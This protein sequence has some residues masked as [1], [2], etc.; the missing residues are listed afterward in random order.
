MAH[1]NPLAAVAQLQDVV[2]SLAPVLRPQVLPKGAS[3]SL[4]LMLAL[5]ATDAQKQQLRA[6]IQDTKPAAGNDDDAELEAQVVGAF[7]VEKKVFNVEKVVWMKQQ[8][9]VIHE[10]ARFVELQLDDPEGASQVI[11]HFLHANGHASDN[12]LAAEQ[13]FNAAFA[14]QTILR[15]FPTPPVAIDGVPVE[16]D[17]D[18]NVAKMF[19]PLFGG[20]KKKEASQFDKK[21]KNRSKSNNKKRKST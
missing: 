15:A 1:V 20:A 4:D 2:H 18:T 13:C 21:K 5:C 14:L 8:D 6:L 3:Y 11:A 12:T 16:V 10:F 19:A 7:D 17:E 9:A